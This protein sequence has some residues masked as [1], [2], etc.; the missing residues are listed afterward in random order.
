MI[1]RCGRQDKLHKQTA[2][3]KKTNSTVSSTT[4]QSREL[5]GVSTSILAA[6]HKNKEFMSHMTAKDINSITTEIATSD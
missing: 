1:L 4:R 2:K 3:N 5:L 6:R